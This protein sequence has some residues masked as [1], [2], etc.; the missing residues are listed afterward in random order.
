MDGLPP[1]PLNQLQSAALQTLRAVTGY[2]AETVTTFTVLEN[3]VSE[4][5]ITAREFDFALDALLDALDHLWSVPMAMYWAGVGTRPIRNSH[6]YE[7]SYDHPIFDYYFINPLG[8]YPNVLG[9][10]DGDCFTTNLPLHIDVTKIERIFN[11]TADLLTL[12]GIARLLSRLYDNC[13]KRVFKHPNDYLVTKTNVGS[14]LRPRYENTYN[15]EYL[16]RPSATWRVTKDLTMGDTVK[17]DR[18][19]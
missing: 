18:I 3:G 7:S 15:I 1:L 12:P 13:S 19:F 17:I 2:A 14:L 4:D 5:R 11:S 8:I 16:G 9:G 6:I 10:D